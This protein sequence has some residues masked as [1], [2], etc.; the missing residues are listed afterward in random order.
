VSALK[1]VCLSDTHLVDPRE[2]PSRCLRELE[3]AELILHAGDFVA[4]N[5]LERLERI[6]A[7]AAVMGNMDEPSLEARL[8]LRRTVEAGGVLLGLVH[9]PGP[10]SGRAARLLAAFPDCDAVVFGHTHLAEARRA[11]KQ[12]LLNPGSATR[13]R[14]GTGPTLVVIELSGGALEPRIATID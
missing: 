14:V 9:D 12:W 2:L 7:V 13:S 8:P 5:V 4:A 1:V 10:A 11:G 6:A 3:G